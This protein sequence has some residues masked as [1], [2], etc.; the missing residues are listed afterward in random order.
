[1]RFWEVIKEMSAQPVRQEATR[2]FVL[3]LAGNP[4]VV[5]E[6]RELVLG[7]KT[8]PGDRAAAEPFL[9]T[10][11][12]PFSSSEEGRLRYA[13]LLVSLPGGPGITDL[14]P[15]DTIEVASVKDLKRSILLHRPDLRVAL[16]RRLPGFRDEAAEYVIRDVSRVNAEFAALSTITQSIPFLAPLFPVVAGADIFLLTKNQAILIF[17]LAAIYGEDLDLKS[18]ARE[19]APVI[20]G[21]FGWRTIARQ[22][23]G[24]LPG[25]MGLPVRA[26]I[27][28]SGTYAVGRAAQMVFDQGRRPTRQEMLRIYEEGR[29]LAQEV[30]TSLRERFRKDKEKE[31]QAP[32]KALPPGEEIITVEAHAE[33]LEPQPAETEATEPRMN[34]SERE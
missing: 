34:A 16:G 22:L 9:C 11:S 24:A 2:L 25:A 32:P 33:A 27:A 17:R 28:F 19:V 15:A 31:L 13:D 29:D 5:A 26:G 14:R 1:M 3:G 18:R 12:P 10:A 30:I 23:A 20:G 8:S 21:A 4:D 7:P 6:A